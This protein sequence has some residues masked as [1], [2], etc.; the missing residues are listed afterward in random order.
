MNYIERFGAQAVMGRTLGMGE[1]RRMMV[2]HNT[3]QAYRNRSTAGDNWAKW[4]QDNP[5][6]RRL[7]ELAEIERG[8][9]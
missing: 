1:M 2:V 8:E 6:Q 5:E 7:I 4:A 3:I 9:R